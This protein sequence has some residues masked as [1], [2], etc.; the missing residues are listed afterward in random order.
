MYI[1]LLYVTSHSDEL[2]LLY[3]W[4]RKW[5]QPSGSGSSLRLGR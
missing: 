5:V 3:Q 4:E 2:S 1:R